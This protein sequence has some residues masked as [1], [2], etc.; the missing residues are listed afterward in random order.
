MRHLRLFQDELDR[1][2]RRMLQNVPQVGF[3]PETQIRLDQLN[4]LGM[5]T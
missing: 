2:N 1:Q 3:D 4:L 5:A